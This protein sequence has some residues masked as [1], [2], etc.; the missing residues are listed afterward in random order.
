MAE[1]FD[2][3][4]AVLSKRFTYRLNH[5]HAAD[6]YR[7]IGRFISTGEGSEGIDLTFREDDERGE[8]KTQTFPIDPTD[9]FTLY[10]RLGMYLQKRYPDS[11]P[12]LHLHEATS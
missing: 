6:I 10:R 5:E 4:F 8:E 12:Q 9:A 7:T 3:H 11:E 1:L 2:I